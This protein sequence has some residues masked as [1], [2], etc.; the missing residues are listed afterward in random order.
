MSGPWTFEEARQAC[1]TASA[2]QRKTETDLR[3]TAKQ[4]ALAEERYRVQLALAIV[5]AHNEGVAWSVASDVARGRR[6]VAELRRLRDIAEGVREATT[7]A[8]WRA[9]ADRRDT[10]AFLT[11]SCRRELAEDSVQPQWT[12][13]QAA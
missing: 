10:A 13:R 1:H 7:Q 11:W 2:L 12:G 8:A 5:E 4:A 9:A 6:D 3:K